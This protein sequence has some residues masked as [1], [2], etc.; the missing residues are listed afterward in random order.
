VRV[1]AEVAALRGVSPEALSDL[2]G[3][4]ARRLFL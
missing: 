4:N 1:L 3:A 2:T